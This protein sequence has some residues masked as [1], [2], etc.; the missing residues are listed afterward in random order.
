[1]IKMTRFT[2]PILFLLFMIISL[3]SVAQGTHPTYSF[4]VFE[5][6]FSNAV[7][8]TNANDGSGRL[9]VIE[10][11]GVIKIIENG[12]TL[13]TPFLD[14]NSIV[15]NGLGERGLLGLAFHPNYQSNGHFFVHYNN[16]SGDTQISRFTRNASNPNIADVASELKI[17]LIDQ[18]DLAGY[19]NH[20]GGSIRFGPNDGYLYVALGDGGSGGD[21]GN[22]AQNKQLLLGKMLRIDVNQSTVVNP[23]DIPSTNPFVGNGTTLDEIWAIGLR[24]PWQFS[25]DRLTGD[26]WI[27]DVGQNAREEINFQLATSPGG[28]NYGWRCYEGTQTYNTSG[29]LSMGSYVFPLFEVPH[30]SGG[31]NSL[32]G[33]FVYRGPNACLNGYYFA[34]EYLRDTVYTIAPQVLGGT[35]N[36]RI[37]AGINNIAAFGEGDDGELYAVKRGSSSTIYRITGAATTTENGNPISPGTYTAAG[38]LES[39]GTVTNGTVNFESAEGIFLN[40]NFEVFLGAIFSGVVGCP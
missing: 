18:P 15:I 13:P 5:T 6:G 20:K 7:G 9:F 8:L 1:M 35:V 14:I 24:N 32:T 10:Q 16:N 22:R 30:S 34:A 28:E 40:P 2:F 12:N 31:G 17:I 11:A 4:E 21:P 36:K 19:E 38:R 3:R 39:S 26:L 37:F 27:G 29:C 25:F 23:Y 33:G